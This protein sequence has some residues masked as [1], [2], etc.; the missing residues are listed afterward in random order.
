[1]KSFKLILFVFIVSFWSCNPDK[2]PAV[3]S[4]NLVSGTALKTLSREEF[5]AK[6]N[7]ALG[8]TGQQ[9]SLFVTS[10][11]KQYKI[12][13]TTTAP[14]GEKITASG[15]LVVPTETKT[16]LALVSYQHGTIFNDTDAPSYFNDQSEATIGTFLASTGFIIAMPDYIGYGDSKNVDHPYEHAPGLSQGT[17]DFLLAVKQF[18]KNEKI[19]W[20]NNLMLAGYSEGGFATMATQKLIEEKYSSEFKLKASSL[21]AGAYNKPLTVENFLKNKTSGEVINNRSYVW[22]MLTYNKLY[23]INRPMTDY[24][25]EPYAAD[26]TKNGFR[27]SINKS[28]DEILQPK[29]K[30]GILDKSDMAWTA[31]LNDNNLTNWKTNTITKLY[32][33]TKDTYVPIINSESAL[34]GLKAKG[35]PNVTLDKIT[36]GTH[37]SSVNAYYLGTLELFNNNKN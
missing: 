36:D 11:I 5:K 24:F 2:E 6:L 4:S 10:G 18:I 30:A 8:A 25:I 9:I 3:V 12:S 27:V 35:S 28:F 17:V 37:S 19:N 26:I 20:N 15:A 29:F 14:S 34:S 21:G 16:P 7:S 23:K 13:Y 32:H 1:M 31:A 22:V 33:G